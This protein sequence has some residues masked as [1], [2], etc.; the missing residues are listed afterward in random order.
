MTISVKDFGEILNDSDKYFYR[1]CND[2]RNI[3]NKDFNYSRNRYQNLFLDQL[4]QL[5]NL[6]NYSQL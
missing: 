6:I 5:D 4:I 3:I 2:F 1:I